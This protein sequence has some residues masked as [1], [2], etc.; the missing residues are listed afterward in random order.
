MIANH[1]PFFCLRFRVG[2]QPDSAIPTATGRGCGFDLAPRSSRSGGLLVNI[3]DGGYGRLGFR[4]SGRTRRPLVLSLII[5]L[6]LTGR[7]V[8]SGLKGCGG[9]AVELMKDI[10]HEVIASVGDVITCVGS[11]V[12]SFGWER[13]SGFEGIDCAM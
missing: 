9:W 6:G 3:D 11:V 4:D 12:A 13:L 10:S 5:L 7:T 2:L 8:R 1:L